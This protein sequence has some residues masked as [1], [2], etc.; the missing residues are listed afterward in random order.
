MLFI[1]VFLQIYF[2]FMCMSVLTY[3]YVCIPYICMMHSEVRQGH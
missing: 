2:Y 1:K 3:T